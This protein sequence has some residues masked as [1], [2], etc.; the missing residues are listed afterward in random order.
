MIV[1]RRARSYPEL[2]LVPGEPVYRTFERDPD[3]VQ[4]VSDPARVAPLWE[5]FEP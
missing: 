1:V 4:W 5:G 3:A 2:G